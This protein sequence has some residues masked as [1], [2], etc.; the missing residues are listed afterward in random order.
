VSTGPREIFECERVRAYLDSYLEG[1]V[2][3]PEARAIQLHFQRCSECHRRVMERE[4]LKIFAPLS[5]EARDDEF[6]AGFWPAVRAEIRKP[7]PAP[8]LLDRLLP[9]PAL[10]WAA[11]AALLLLSG[12]AL[13]RPWELAMKEPTGGLV[14]VDPFLHGG[15]GDQATLAPAAAPALPAV[16]EVRSPTAHVLTMKVI[17]EDRAVTEVVLIVDEAIEL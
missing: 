17:G 15:A 10:A 9:K 7:L 5:E 2:P 13:M 14:A 3:P 11:A 8:S 16:E 1:Q 4:P 6:W 12:L